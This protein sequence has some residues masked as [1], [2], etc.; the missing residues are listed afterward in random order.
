M[1]KTPKIS[2]FANVYLNKHNKEINMKNITMY[3]IK[4]FEFQWAKLAFFVEK[5]P[6]AILLIE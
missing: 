6:D 1:L 2:Y 5:P 4:G 3:C